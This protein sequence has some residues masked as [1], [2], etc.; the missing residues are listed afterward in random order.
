MLWTKCDIEIMVQ[1]K[2]NAL[3]HRR[4]VTI[5][6]DWI[7]ELNTGKIQKTKKLTAQLIGDLLSMQQRHRKDFNSLHLQR[8][9]NADLKLSRAH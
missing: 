2:H 1:G 6:H 4:Q 5:Q 7:N 8:A 9:Y 3:E